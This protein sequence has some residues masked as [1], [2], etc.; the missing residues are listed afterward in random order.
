MH[1]SCKKAVLYLGKQITEICKKTTE[2][3]CA[4]V[5]RDFFYNNLSCFYLL[6]PLLNIQRPLKLLVTVYSTVYHGYFSCSLDTD[7]HS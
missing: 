4:S 2:S 1:S 7:S 6:L 5:F 3:C